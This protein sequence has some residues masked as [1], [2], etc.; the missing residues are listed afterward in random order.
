MTT[1]QRSQR[2][3]G[4][5]AGDSRGVT[6]AAGPG[7]RKKTS[8]QRMMGKL[9]KRRPSWGAGGVHVRKLFEHNQLVPSIRKSINFT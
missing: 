8:R 5:L 4:G 2:A 1:D 9:K 7:Q 6:A 3:S